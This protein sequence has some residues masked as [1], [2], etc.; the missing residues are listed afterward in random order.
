MPGKIEGRRRR[1]WQRMNWL[2]GITDSMDM[3][4]SKLQKLV[5]ARVVWH[6]AVC[7]VAKSWTGLSEWTD[8]N[9]ILVYCISPIWS[10]RNNREFWVMYF[11]MNTN[12]NFNNRNIWHLC[13]FT[14]EFYG[15]H[16]PKNLIHK[17]SSKPHNN[18]WGTYFCI[19][20]FNLR[21]RNSKRLTNC[22]MLIQ[23]VNIKAKM[24][25]FATKD[26]NYWFIIVM[27]HWLL[28]EKVENSDQISLR[29]K[30]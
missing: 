20:V 15:K 11:R 16:S 26:F 8:L 6:S 23:L 10:Y 4:L 12:N 27:N 19:H 3:S 30:K 21:K 25:I 18:P 2:D 17:T 13:T 5:M 24:R 29:K 9:W 28:I 7:G 14:H 1:G 22:L